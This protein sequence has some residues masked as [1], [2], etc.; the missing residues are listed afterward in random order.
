MRMFSGS[1][2][3]HDDGDGAMVPSSWKEDDEPII[4]NGV[5]P[6]E[7]WCSICGG[8]DCRDRHDEDEEPELGLFKA[9]RHDVKG[10]IETVDRIVARYRKR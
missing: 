5:G 8:T 3:L 1:D 2:E 7:G 10:H 9:S 4:Q 6:E